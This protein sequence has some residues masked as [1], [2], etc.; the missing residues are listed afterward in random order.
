[1]ADINL[2]KAVMYAINQEDF[3]AYS[4]GIYGQLYSSF[5]TLINTGNVLKQDLAKSAEYL[6]AYHESQAQ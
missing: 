5:S 2:R 4:E 3:V 1:M 6:K